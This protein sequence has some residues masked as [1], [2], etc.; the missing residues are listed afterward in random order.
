MT[1]PVGRDKRGRS[2]L[3]AAV[4]AL[5]AVAEGADDVVGVGALEG[6]PVVG[7]DGVLAAS[8]EADDLVAGLHVGDVGD[9][10]GRV[11]HRDASDHGA[12]RAVD[13][14]VAA[15]REGE[16]QT[17]RVAGGDRRHARALR[18][19][20]GASVAERGAGGEVADLGDAGLEGEDRLHVERAAS[21]G[22]E[23]AVQVDAGADLREGAACGAREV[24]S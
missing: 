20:P 5:D 1:A 23:G 2:R 15:V 12:G 10:H 4:D 24:V 6:G 16:G 7:R 21:V 3:P 11:V 13:Q 14:H 22:V 19:A 8:A 9:V 17:V 18:E